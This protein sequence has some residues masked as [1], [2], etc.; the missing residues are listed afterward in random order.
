MVLLQVFVRLCVHFL[1]GEVAAFTSLAPR[2]VPM[3]RL[4]PDAAVV[5]FCFLCAVLY[6]IR[7][8]FYNK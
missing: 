7:Q 1:P 4:R 5:V 2:V 6:K 8:R 3:Q